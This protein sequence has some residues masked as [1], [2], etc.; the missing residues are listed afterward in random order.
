M[1]FGDL[2]SNI[3]QIYNSPYYSRD[4]KSFFEKQ[5]HLKKEKTPQL[6]EILLSSLKNQ[7][8]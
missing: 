8:A 3:G 6:N 7:N 4:V 2:S 1:A 5:K